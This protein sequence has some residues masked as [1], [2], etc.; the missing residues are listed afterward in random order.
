MDDPIEDSVRVST[1]DGYLDPSRGPNNL[2]IF[3]EA[4][5]DRVLFEGSRAAGVRVRTG[6]GWREVRGATV[7]LSAGAVHSPV[8]LLRSGVGPAE[9]LVLSLS[10]TA[11]QPPSPP[12]TQPSSCRRRRCG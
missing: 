6:G 4:H 11:P 10:P 9:H 3:G 1:N 7:I 8:I 2:A 5:V 12:W